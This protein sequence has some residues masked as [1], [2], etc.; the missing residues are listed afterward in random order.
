M[1]LSSTWTSKPEITGRHAGLPGSN[2]FSLAA[3]CASAGGSAKV[4]RGKRTNTPL[5]CLAG[6]KILNCRRSVKSAKV[7]AA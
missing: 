4:G 5:L 3:R 6:S 1:A 7:S 2:A